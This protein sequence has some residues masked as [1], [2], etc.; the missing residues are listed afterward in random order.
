MSFVE[1][2]FEDL[3]E[4]Q[5]GA[6]LYKGAF[7]ELEKQKFAIRMGSSENPNIYNGTNRDRIVKWKEMYFSRP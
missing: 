7:T 1:K 5:Y 6:P 3:W 4:E 2:S